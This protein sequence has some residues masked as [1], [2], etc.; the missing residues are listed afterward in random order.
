M[1]C[2]GTPTEDWLRR[3]AL[4]SIKRPLP[5]TQ[6]GKSYTQDKD[7]RGNHEQHIKLPVQPSLIT[8]AQPI[9]TQ[10]DQNEN[11]PDDQTSLHTTKEDTNG[12][13]KMSIFPDD[14]PAS[15]NSIKE[16]VSEKDEKDGE[17]YIPLHST[18]VLK[19]RGRM[20]YLTLEFR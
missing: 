16:Y 11:A 17:T 13:N 8:I 7:Y 19:K 6:Q 2:N 20:L 10:M 4:A 1:E 14:F 18:I 15:F 3:Q 12:S 5:Q 9:A